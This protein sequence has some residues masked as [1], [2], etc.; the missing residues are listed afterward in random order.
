MVSK[1]AGVSNGFYVAL[2]GGLTCVLSA[3][4]RVG[5]HHMCYIPLSA[6]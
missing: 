6:T 2:I 1:Q 3:S 4:C 5:M